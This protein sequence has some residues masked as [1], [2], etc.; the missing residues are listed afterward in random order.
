VTGLFLRYCWR[1]NSTQ[2][3]AA[4]A[5]AGVKCECGEALRIVDAHALIPALGAGM[6]E[7]ERKAIVEDLRG[8][9]RPT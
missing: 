9:D 8:H 7:A 1:C 5:E 4:A 3:V 2:T 6:L